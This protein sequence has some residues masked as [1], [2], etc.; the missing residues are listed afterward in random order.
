MC[1]YSDPYIRASGFRWVLGFSGLLGLYPVLW[2]VF[3]LYRF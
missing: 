2:D 3:G 1:K